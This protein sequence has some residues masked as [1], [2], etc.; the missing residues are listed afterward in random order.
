[1]VWL[2]AAEGGFRKGSQRFFRWHRECFGEEAIGGNPEAASSSINALISMELLKVLKG[3]KKKS[4]A[5]HSDPEESFD[6][7]SQ[8]DSSHGKKGGASRA[9][10]AHRRGHRSM[11]RN[12]MRHVKRY[13]REVEH[14]LGA[15][16]Q[17]AYSLSDCSKKL[18]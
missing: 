14:F 17:T 7:S 8:T 13:M 3:K 12:P 4:R 2:P 5:P 18:N 15:S 1:M 10:R 6:S 11:R 16:P 9:L